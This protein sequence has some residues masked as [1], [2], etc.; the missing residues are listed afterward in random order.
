MPA[1]LTPCFSVALRP[2][3]SM[4]LCSGKAPSCRKAVRRWMTCTSRWV[5][6]R[7]ACCHWA[8]ALVLP[9]LL[10]KTASCTYS[11]M[12]VCTHAQMCMHARAHMHA[13]V[14]THT[15]IHCHPNTHCHKHT[16][17]LAHS[18]SLSLSHTHRYTETH[19]HT[20]TCTHSLSRSLAHSHKLTQTL[21][22]TLAHT[23]SLTHIHSLLEHP[24]EH[25]P[26]AR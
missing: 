20:L 22:H 19:T 12:H 23:H 14:H 1:R 3:S 7:Y 4:R 17:T 16:H 15:H 2:C 21:S 10:A 9:V 18:L 25:R 26:W 8:A 13:R 6:W 24:L 5:T 11:R